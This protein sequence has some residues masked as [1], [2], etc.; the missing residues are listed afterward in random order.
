MDKRQAKWIVKK[1]K[2]ENKNLV[3][4]LILEIA[5]AGYCNKAISWEDLKTITDVINYEYFGWFED[6]TDEGRRELLH[7][8]ADTF[9]RLGPY[10]D[11]YEK[12]RA[13]PLDKRVATWIK[14]H[15][16]SGF[17]KRMLDPYWEGVYNDAPPKVKRYYKLKWTCY[18]IP[19]WPERRFRKME[20]DF[21]IRDWEYVLLKSHG[22][23]WY[24]YKL[25]MLAH[26]PDY[27]CT[28]DEQ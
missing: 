22:F 14:H 19:Y 23:E 21:D 20:D 16:I 7:S 18:S 13:L 15:P 9:D 2:E 10:M 26:F 25:K 12:L 11:E 1:L 4:S 6:I 17:K 27:V 8:S 28:K 3:N 24:D 5:Q